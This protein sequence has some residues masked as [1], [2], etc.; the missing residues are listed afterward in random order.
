MAASH[1]WALIDAER[2]RELIT[3]ICED[4]VPRG[5]LHVELDLTD[6]CNVACYFCNQQD[7]RTTQ[8]ISFE[9]VCALIDE[10]VATG[11]KSVRFS[12]GGDPL[13][14]RDFGRVLDHLARRGVVV[15][16]LTTNA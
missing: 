11:L 10:L 7:V 15:D 13:A 5:P 4:A 12:G 14:H 9:H 8:Q 1:G 2:K 6:R 16:N 3:A